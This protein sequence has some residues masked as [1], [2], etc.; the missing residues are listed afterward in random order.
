MSA[1][2]S[3]KKRTTKPIHEFFKPYLRNTVPAKRPSPSAEERKE[4]EHSRREETTTPKAEKRTIDTFAARTPP[5]S[6]LSPRSAP[7]SR[8]SLSIRSRTS[9]SQSPIKPPSTYKRA[10]TF[11]ADIL[12]DDIPKGEA[13]RFS[14][15]DLPSSTQAVIKDGKVIEVLDSDDDDEESLESLEDLFGRRQGGHSTSP[16]STPEHEAK[17]E[18]ER[19]R[20]LSLFTSG[21]SV[22]LVGKDKLR[23]L[24]AKERAHRFDISALMEDHFNDEEVES[25]VREVR[26][27]VDAANKAAGADSIPTLDKTLLAAVATTDDDEHR[28]A[29]LMDAVDRTEALTSEAVFLFFGVNGPNDWHDEDPVEYPFPEDAIPEHLWRAG[30]N[31]SRSRAYVSGCMADLAARRLISDGALNWTFENVVMEEQDDVRQAYIRCLRNASSSWTRINIQAQDVQAIFQTLGAD[32]NSLQ[33][34]VEIKP[35]HR[36]LKEPARRDPKYLLA[37]LDVFQEIYADMDFLALSKLTSII[38]RLAIDSELT[39][40]GRISLSIDAFLERLLS[41]PDVET[42]SHIADRILADMGRHLKDSTLQA[43]LLSHILPT[44]PTA[45]QIRILL[46]QAFLLGA[47]DVKDIES[48][49]PK[50]SLHTLAEHVSKSPDFDTRRR[51]GPSTMDY[52]ALRARSHILDIAI[53]DGGRPAEFP[54]RPEELSFNKSVDRLADAIKATFVAIVDTGASHMTRT[55]C[56]D[57]LQALYWRLLYSVRTELRPKRHIF[58]GKVGRLRDAEE[59]QVEERGKDF[60]SRFLEKTKGKSR[61]RERERE[62]EKGAEQTADTPQGHE[63]AQKERGGEVPPTS[64]PTSEPSETE[65]SIRRQLGLEN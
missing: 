6:V 9:H 44:S 53:S 27:E 21:R 3:S 7:G 20:L 17:A 47:N 24:Y 8:A 18:A 39:S 4:G 65:M 60:M 48:N 25:K 36:L 61:E 23:A 13:N 43:Q 1:S 31:E 54:S 42:R 34:S 2:P 40:D 5:S 46:A 52:T 49:T 62:R 50:I 16:L 29:R 14:F 11:G 57:V 59:V 22:P 64:P 12:E 19:K 41:L 30:D 38:C 51:K 10:P 15:T 55:E 35:R 45:L 56:K 32:S 63:N 37:V 58:D 33:D 28:V 26:A